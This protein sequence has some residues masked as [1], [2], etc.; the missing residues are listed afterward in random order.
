MLGKNTKSAAIRSLI[1]SQIKSR[2]HHFVRF[3]SDQYKMS[4]QA[5][6]RHIRWLEK[7]R[8]IASTGKTKGKDY[9]LGENRYQH[10][11]Y[12]LKGLDENVVYLNDFDHVFANLPSN[13]DEICHYGFT[14]MLN[15]AIDHSEGNIVNIIVQNIGGEISIYIFDD[16]E[17]IFDRIARILKLEN[18]QESLLELSKGKLTTD[19][20]N[21]SGEGIFFT[22]R[23]FETF[24]IF[25]GDLIFTPF[26]QYLDRLEYVDDTSRG[27][28]I[29]MKTSS[30]SK[31][32]IG[33][34]FDQFSSGPDEYRFEKTVIPVRLV[35]LEGEK[36][37]S[38]SQAKRLM[39]RVDKF[40]NVVLDFTDVGFIGQAFADEVFR[41][42]ANQ[43]PE[44]RISAE[45]LN[46]NGIKMMKRAL[47]RK[48]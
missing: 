20:S 41:V 47:S 2:N 32:N 21:H 23:A 28:N 1:L 35:K 45:N 48:P 42:Y 19:P 36:L 5:V 39:R 31:K 12:K 3:V 8:Y 29:I 46:A 4:V 16:G 18:A 13:I 40:E 38:R 34:V 7:H 15:N 37:V 24:A 33:E 10:Q 43:H 17:G 25:S 44:I 30:K 27:T 22:S 6:H 11:T 26:D 9:F 14:E